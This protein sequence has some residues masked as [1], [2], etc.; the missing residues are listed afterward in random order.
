MNDLRYKWIE[1]IILLGFGAMIIFLFARDRLVFFVYPKYDILIL[2]GGVLLAILGVY[3]L[4]RK[5][6]LC[7]H[8]EPFISIKFS[9]TLML[10][11]ILIGLLMTPKPLS[12]QTAISR[13]VSTDLAVLEG[14][15]QK[16]SYQS[17]PEDRSLADWIRMFNYDPEPDKYKGDKIKVTGFVLKDAKLPENY[18]MITQFIIACCAADA[19]PIGLPV[20]YELGKFDLAED[21][22]LELEGEI[23]EGKIG[24][25]RRAVIKLNKYKKIETPENPYAY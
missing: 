21:T 20:Q 15:P 24:D 6:Q 11:P 16:F 25:Q 17:K 9:A 8:H 10:I 18:F 23:V 12:V 3:N 2:A 4:F 5:R 13:G 7:C 19:R 14:G 22:W 1:T